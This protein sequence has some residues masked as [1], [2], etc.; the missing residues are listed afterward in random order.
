MA[1]FDNVMFVEASP[2]QIPWREHY[3]TKIVVPPHM[4]AVL[5]SSGAELH[6]VLAPGGEIHFETVTT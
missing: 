5:R 4:E 2:Q 6:R 1:E 3:F